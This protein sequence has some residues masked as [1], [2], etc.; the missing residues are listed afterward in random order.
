[1][2]FAQIEATSALKSILSVL[3]FRFFM[4]GLEISNTGFPSKIGTFVEKSRFLEPPK[5]QGFWNV[6]VF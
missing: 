2:Q 1:M 3:K 5:N 6:G 4:G